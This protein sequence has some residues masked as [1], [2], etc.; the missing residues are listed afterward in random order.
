MQAVG[1]RAGYSRALATHRFGSKAGLLANVARKA[2]ADW[3]AR[4]E[5]AVGDRVGV[6]ALCAATDAAERYIRECPNEVRALYILWFLSIDI[7]TDY[8]PNIANVHRAQ[9]RDVERWIRSGKAAGGVDAGI[10]PAR[11]AE[12]YVASMAGIAYQWLMNREMPLSLMYRQ[13]K[14]NIRHQL[15]PSRASRIARQSPARRKAGARTPAS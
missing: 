8:R 15:Q 6:E 11:V 5:Q 13:L 9:R 3:I 10:S 7:D 4:V 14:A 2:G 1:E 12:Q